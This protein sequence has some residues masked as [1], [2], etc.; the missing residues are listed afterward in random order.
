[1]TAILST[2]G[3]ARGEREAFWRQ[4]LSETFVP[5][6]VG[7]I[8]EDR[9]GGVIRADWVGRLMVA[10]VASTAQDVQRTSREIGRTDAEYLQLGLVYRGAAR[11]T[12]DGREV[13]LHPGDYTIHETTRPF[14]WTFGADWDVGV[15]TLPRASVPL[16]QAQS[17]LLTARRLDGRT[18]ITGV[19]S[20]FLQDLARH[21][22]DLSG[23]QSE[24][25]LADL[26]DLVLN[27]ARREGRRQPG[28]AQQRAAHPD[29][30]GQGLHPGSAGG[31]DAGAGRDRHRG[32]H[33]HPVSAH[34]VCGRAPVGVAAC[35]G[36]AAGAVPA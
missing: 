9:F 5:M 36:V 23:T 11:V 20:R 24:R 6:R 28:G 25:V 7:E 10:Q 18:G 21:A 8:A 3:V 30:P 15:F 29:G 13:V 22:D 27:P 34:A 17:R 12:Q 14:R 2:E 35:S 33:L 31:S 1:V 19:V 26:T 32:Q 16:S 4:A